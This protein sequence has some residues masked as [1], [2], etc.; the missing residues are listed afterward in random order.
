MHI[1]CV[2]Q[3]K[4]NSLQRALVIMGYIH[5]EAL[6]K[7]ILINVVHNRVDIIATQTTF[8]EFVEEIMKLAMEFPIL[9]LPW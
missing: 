2:K 8:G 3:R 6:F 5:V 4:I 7:G 9:K 1:C